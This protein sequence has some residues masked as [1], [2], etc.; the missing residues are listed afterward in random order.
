MR[1]VARQ[2]SD[3]LTWYCRW[4]DPW[5]NRWRDENLNT[6]DLV[7]DEER[8]AWA[9]AKYE[10]LRHERQEARAARA[11]GAP[12]VVTIRAAVERYLADCDRR[13]RPLTVGQYRVS[14]ER[15]AGW[16]RK[17]G[18][19][20]GRE[21]TAG[22]LWQYRSWAIGNREWKRSTRRR[23]LMVIKAA[24]TWWRRAGFTPHLTGDM[25]AD[26]FAGLAVPQSVVRCLR[27]G[28]VRALLAAAVAYPDPRASAFVA[29]ALLTGCRVA[30]ME[31][32]G[33][34]EVDLEAPPGG[35]IRLAMDEDEARTKTHRGRVIDLAV[36]STA[37]D[38]FA[39]L[40]RGGPLVFG[41][42]A[43]AA[44]R[45]WLRALQVLDRPWTW[46]SLRQTT[47]SYLAC[48][49]SIFGAASLVRESRQLGHG[50]EI[51]MRHYV[52]TL[53]AIPPDATVLEH[54]MEAAEAFL[55]VVARQG[56]REAVAC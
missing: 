11:A 23:H 55:A 54:A 12:P 29:L 53:R 9:R 24:L 42:D 40:P 2:R 35:E 22:V 43:K 28:E 25:I 51:A 39:A 45:R 44:T 34:H 4:L 3:G 31:T 32:L 56:A 50:T 20:G 26:S 18:I 7:T 27:P 1:L 52:G 19:A 16:L 17:H 37:R 47:A 15:F 33:W 10:A 41:N 13:L 46:R 14:L 6:L 38:L 36:S 30:E 48:A 49:P 5:S 8:H 21:I